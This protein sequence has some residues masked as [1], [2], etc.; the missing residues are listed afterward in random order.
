VRHISYGLGIFHTSFHFVLLLTLVSL[1]VDSV[2]ESLGP[3]KNERYALHDKI[4]KSHL[5]SSQI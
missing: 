5:I 4:A 2:S 1:I 3:E